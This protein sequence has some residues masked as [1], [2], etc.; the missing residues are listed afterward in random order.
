MKVRRQKPGRCVGTTVAL[1]ALVL[2]AGGGCRREPPA[3]PASPWKLVE[4]AHFAVRTDGEPAQYQ[5][6][7]D[8]LEDMHEAV[9]ATFFTGVPMPPIDVLL[10]AR[11]GDFKAVA[12]D[13]HLVGFFS[14]KVAGLAGGLLVFSSQAE[15]PAAVAATAAHEVGHRFLVE[16]SERVPTWLHEGFAEYLGASRIAGDR[17][18]FDAAPRPSASTPLADPLPLDRLLAS[19]PADFH[20]ADARSQYMTAWMLMR[21]LLRAPGATSLA[22]FHLLVARSAAASSPEAQRVA[23]RE[24]F[25][26]A[27]LEDVEHAI[28]ASYQGL[29]DGEHVPD[30]SASLTAPLR[31]QPRPPLIVTPLDAAAVERLVAELRSH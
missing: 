19:S 27:A 24:A 17:M 23:V 28:E 7:L 30:V 11:S 29:L 2:G 16:V 12:P 6:V 21:Q 22:R 10:Y 3:A 5:P 25:G 14:S 1:L 8:R 15:D 20:G 9:S 4:S 18:V 26:G 13:Q 31:R